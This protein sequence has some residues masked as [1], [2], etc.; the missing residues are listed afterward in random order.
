MAFT[1]TLPIILSCEVAKVGDKFNQRYEIQVIALVDDLYKLDEKISAAITKDNYIFMYSEEPSSLDVHMEKTRVFDVE[2]MR[3]CEQVSK[4][5]SIKYRE[6][7]LISTEEIAPEPKLNLIITEHIVD[8]VEEQNHLPT[9]ERKWICS[10]L[11]NHLFQ[12]NDELT[13]D[14][15]LYT[16]AIIDA[17]LR[18]KVLGYFDLA[19]DMKS[20]IDVPIANFFKGKA[21]IEFE[22][23]APYLLDL[24]LAENAFS[25]TN[26]VPKFHI[27]FFAD[28]WGHSTNIFIRT[29]ASTESVIQHFKK[30]TKI[31]DENNKWYFFRFWEPRKIIDFLSETDAEQQHTFF[32]IKTEH[33][34][35]SFE[36]LVEDGSDKFKTCQYKPAI[37]K[38]E[39]IL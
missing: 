12:K 26:K 24:T 25:D 20:R 14:N 6:I 9:Y 28:H 39:G 4:A 37:D 30:F 8:E 16:Y 17:T 34:E 22:K 1:N 5:D 27:D 18:T 7:R 21:A 10:N 15:K 33:G 35:E 29:K 11:K 38:A 19:G 31:Q 2:C 36:L 3:L 13:E 32:A 23:S